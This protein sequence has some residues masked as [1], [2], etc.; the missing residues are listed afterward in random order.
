MHQMETNHL[1]LDDS[2]RVHLK[3]IDD[4]VYLGPIDD[5]EHEVPTPLLAELRELVARKERAE[6]NAR[7]DRRTAE[8]ADADRHDPRGW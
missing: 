5:C 3:C 6:E 1:V 4:R 7:Q 8:A 2:D